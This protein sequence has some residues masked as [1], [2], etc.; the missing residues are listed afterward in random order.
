VARTVSLGGTSLLLATGAHLAGG[1][2]LPPTG[3]L[4]VVAFLVGL[5]AVTLTARRLRLGVL[6]AV[7]GIEQAVLHVVFDAASMTGAG[8][9]PSPLGSHAATMAGCLGAV[10]G[11]GPGAA[12]PIAAALS[13]GRLMLIAHLVAT[14]ASAWLLARGEHWWWR[15]WDRVVE[16]ATWTATPRVRRPRPLRPVPVRVLLGAD[17]PAAISP[18]GPPVM[19]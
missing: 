18:R 6:V 4:A 9:A 12:V 2:R 17:R 19:A 11:T 16:A 5:T 15:S 8:C 3:V 1:G 7:L 13:A 10:P 14:L